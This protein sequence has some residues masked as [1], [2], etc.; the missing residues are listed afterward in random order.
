M[1]DETDGG[2]ASESAPPQPAPD[3]AGPTDDQI[4]GL[5][6][7]T[8]TRDAGGVLNMVQGLVGGDE[9][10]YEDASRQLRE[11]PPTE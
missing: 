4:I 1:T 3:P 9:F 5:L 8:E 7:G 6:V 11:H 10:S 2:Q